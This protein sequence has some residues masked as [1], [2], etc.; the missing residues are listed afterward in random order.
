MPEKNDIARVK[1]CTDTGVL[2]AIAAVTMIVDHI[3]AVLFPGDFWLRTIGRISWPLFAYCL[4]VGFICTRS[5]KKYALRL[6]VFGLVSQP[7]YMW[8]FTPWLFSPETWASQSFDYLWNSFDLNIFFTLLLGLAAIYG[9]RE[10]K[11]MLTLATVALSFIPAVSYGFMGVALIIV[12]WMMIYSETS[13]F[14]AVLAL[15]CGSCFLLR[16]LNVDFGFCMVNIQGF[17]ILAV[18]FMCMRTHTGWRLPKYAYYIFYPAHLLV[19]GM[20]ANKII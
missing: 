17:S 16:P 3:G 9:L 2:K 20:I 8:A 5:V 15:M 14:A 6:L 11:Y 10:R 7:V 12:I 18:P 4:V 1:L 13:S 19:L